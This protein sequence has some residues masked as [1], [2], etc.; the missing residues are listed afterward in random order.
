MEEHG[1]IYH[2]YYYEPKPS[3][4]R[5]EVALPFAKILTGIAKGMAIGGAIL[6]L[7]SFLPS[8]WYSLTAST[9]KA[10]QILGQP[11]TQEGRTFEIVDKTYQPR[12][13][14]KLPLESRL[15]IPAIGVDTAI[16][17]ATA[18]NYEEA[19][20]KG[21][22]RVSDFGS[23]AD[24]S[25]PTILTAH[26]YGYLAWSNT[27][28]RKNSFYNLPKLNVGDTVEIYWKQRKY[29]YEIYAEDKGETISDYSGD[30]VLYTCEALN[31]SAKVFKYARLLEI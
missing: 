4:K 23:P 11:V 26:R 15:K 12:F 16:Q 18:D 6:I 24:R 20:K 8:V 5:V 31:S 14:P 25:F 3:S 2:A 13:D 21:T 28:R 30:L 22:W 19:L 27:F 29:V 10:S 17:E 1:I 9:E 7:A